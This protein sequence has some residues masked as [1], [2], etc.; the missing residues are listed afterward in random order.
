[1][2]HSVRKIAIADNLPV[3]EPLMDALHESERTMNPHT[4]QWDSIREK[5]IRY[6][7][8]VERENHAAF[9]VAEKGKEVVGFIFGYVEEPDE[10]DFEEGEGLD[11][12]V[13][14][15]YVKENYRKQGIYTAL[16][17]FL[18]EY[19]KSFPFRRIYRYTLLKNTTMQQWLD[20]QG[21]QPVRM[22]YEKWKE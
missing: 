15:G 11:L 2:E 13:S 6:M 17:L 10:S 8:D 3:I 16:N 22:V 18:E 19:Y 5:Y 12:Y 14:E 20:S 4:S 7:L 9:V 21:Y 1:M